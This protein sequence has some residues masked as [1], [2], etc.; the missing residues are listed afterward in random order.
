MA[1]LTALV[2]LGIL[3]VTGAVICISNLLAERRARRARA[4]ARLT[5]IRRAD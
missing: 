4:R 5:V 2:C 3:A 1:E